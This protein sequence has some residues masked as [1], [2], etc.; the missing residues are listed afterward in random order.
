LDKHQLVNLMN[1][2]EWVRQMEELN[3]I[4]FIVEKGIV[5]LCAQGWKVIIVDLV[6]E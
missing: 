4:D 3:V 5:V 1:G 6:K 2:Y